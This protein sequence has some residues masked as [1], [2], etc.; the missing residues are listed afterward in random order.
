MRFEANKYGSFA[1][2]N[3]NNLD[4]GQEA[5]EPENEAFAAGNDEN[6]LH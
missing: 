3:E 2:A 1:A 5:G 6:A 4:G